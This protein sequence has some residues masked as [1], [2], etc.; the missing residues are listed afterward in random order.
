MEKLNFQD[1][2]FLRLE[3]PRHPFHVGGLMIFT[4]PAEAPRG[5]LRKLA[6]DLA[7][8]LP[9]LDALFRVKLEGANTLSPHWVETTDYEAHYHL[10]HYALPQP[11]RIEDLLL[12][13]SRVHEQLLERSRPLWQWHLIEGLPGG[14]FALYCKIHHALIDGAGA[15]RMINALLSQD[16]Q[17]PIATG[18][19]KT[20]P[21]Q[22]GVTRTRPRNWLQNMTHSA[23][24][25]LE[26]SRA[27][28]EL[29]T[30]LLGMRKQHD[31]AAPPLPF[32]A[33]HAIMNTDI[34]QRRR[35]LISDFPLASIRRVGAAA[36]G[37]VNDVLLAICGG[38]LRS[39]L[40]EQGALPSQPLLAG[41][42][43]SVRTPGEHH[44]N[45]LSTIVCSFGT[46]M[47][48]PA[49]RLRSIC[50]MTRQAKRDVQSL[51][52]TARQDYMNLILLPA[53]VLTLAHAATSI[54]PAFNVIVSN[55][56][57]PQQPL[58]LAGSRLD[59][60]YP[61][62]VITDAQALN[63]TAVSCGKRLCLGI[64]SC[65]DNL[66][67]IERLAP[68]MQSAWRELR[69]AMLQG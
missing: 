46:N 50:R 43:V 63:I 30:M 54:P 27:I 9:R 8:D 31:E 37:T 48:D 15:L 18:A 26:Q 44:G 51:S 5:Y 12:S 35:V 49:R 22:Q 29:A 39:Y 68:L 56:P 1:A 42:P 17:S 66:P 69:Q 16:P 60:I 10:H 25:V 24:T 14:R 32:S 21:A 11:G 36:G 7:R 13:V 67:A 59:E 55:V 62:S 64:T 34:S 47:R 28:P 33:P 20:G 65:P 57:G 2:A 61:L 40:M 58:Y 23:E 38:A 53:V 45:E 41:I 4:P 3:D 19:V 52:Q 6:R